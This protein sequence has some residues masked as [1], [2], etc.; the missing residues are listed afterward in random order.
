MKPL[1]SI[2]VVAL[3]PGEK[4]LQ[5]LKSI[6]KQTCN[7]YEVVVKD[8]GSKDYSIQEMQQFLKEKPSFSQRVHFYNEPD[9]SIYDAMN[10]AIHYTTGQ[11]I[12]F[13]NCGDLFYD[14]QVLQK[15][16][17]NLPKELMQKCIVYGDVFD[18]LR[19]ER[20]ASN[21]R[22]D[23]FACYRNVPCHQACFY[24][25]DLFNER[26]YNVKYKVRADY[27]HF[28]WSYFKKE[29]KM[30]Y[31]PV[32]IA[33]YEGGGFSETR[34]NRKRSAKEHKE[35]TALYLTKGQRFKYSFIMWITL[36]PLR[37]KLA[38]SKAFSGIYQKLKRRLYVRRT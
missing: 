5:T 20:V 13:L 1:F 15:V 19:K 24:H 31:V 7:D 12:S 21:P 4:L 8:G 29:A 18:A 3:N 6:E 22:I 28:L 32:I 9:H 33:S 30:H 23:A 36:A 14:S 11:F 2:V 25:R 10:Q 35:I 17:D 37:T 26:K 34:E 16:K 38:E 27:E